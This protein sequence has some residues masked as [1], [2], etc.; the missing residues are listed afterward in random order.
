MNT[1]SKDTVLMHDKK[2]NGEN[3]PET[4]PYICCYL[5]HVKNTN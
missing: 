1:Y 5:I 2:T 3:R 4:N